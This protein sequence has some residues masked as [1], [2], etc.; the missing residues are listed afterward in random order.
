MYSRARKIL[1][2]AK[3]AAKSFEENTSTPSEKQINVTSGA[4]TTVD[5]CDSKSDCLIENDDGT[6]LPVQTF[7]EV[8]VD[9]SGL[10]TDI[11]E[12]CTKKSLEENR[13]FPEEG[14]SNSTPDNTNVGT[15][16]FQSGFFIVNDD[17]TLFPIQ[18]VVGDFAFDKKSLKPHSE[19]LQKKV[20]RNTEHLIEMDV[21]YTRNED[22]VRV[23]PD[24][25]VDG[26]DTLVEV[27]EVGNKPILKPKP[28]VSLA[29]NYVVPYGR[30]LHEQ[31]E[32]ITENLIEMDEPH[33]GI[34]DQDI[35]EPDRLCD[36]NNQLS[37]RKRKKRHQVSEDDWQCNQ[38]KILRE[39]GREYMGRKL[40][41]GKV[42][43]YI[44]RPNR[45]MKKITCKC[46][47]RTFKCHNISEQE[48][49]K[50]FDNFWAL[51]WKERKMLVKTS[52]DADLTQRARDRSEENRSRRSY[53]YK[54]YL[55]I[56]NMTKVR[57][58]KSTL[59]ATL[60][61]GE[62]M[63]KNWLENSSEKDDDL[64]DD[65]NPNENPTKMNENTAKKQNAKRMSRQ[66]DLSKRLESLKEFLLT[67][68]NV[69]SHYCRSSSK[70]LYLEPNW[71]SKAQLYQFY[72]ENWCKAKDFKPLSSCTFHKTFEDLNLSLYR[73]KKDQCDTCR[74]YKLNHIT[75]E[76]FET[77]RTKKDEAREEKS[78]DKM[79][80]EHVY[81]VDLQSLLLCPK[82]NAS[83]LYYRRKLSVHNLTMFDLKTKDGFCYLWNETEGE[84]SANEFASILT[85]FVESQL[86]LR[87]N[88][89]KI[90]IFSDGC[91]Y[92]NRSAVMSNALL[93][94]AAKHNITIESKYLE[95]GH[96]QMECDSMHAT[97]ERYLRHREINVPAD[98]ID[99]CK[100]ARQSNP[101]KVIYLDH[102]FFKDFTKPLMFK[103]IRP[104]IRK[105]DPKV[106][107]IRCLKYDSNGKI[108]YKLSFKDDFKV[109]PACDDSKEKVDEGSRKSKRKAQDP[110]KSLT[111][112][113]DKVREFLEAN[114]Q[115]L[116]NDRLK[117]TAAKYQHLQELKPSIVKD[118]HSF[119]DNLPM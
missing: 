33:T 78:K 94:V 24:I 98:Y 92:Q 52:T 106:T 79:N 73:P 118:Y 93:H 61:L 77:H 71:L 53:S 70:K 42:T 111:S 95:K 115:P 90:V 57:V 67:L 88:A 86:P 7:N 8:T 18:T 50:I 43:G 47:G 13:S 9:D 75:E 87:N 82:S 74:A 39:Q 104:G 16:D 65:P 59:L 45:T 11:V 66:H 103:S 108:H 29:E 56:D 117:I 58:C 38:A 76:D 46:K 69:E 100:N 6:L 107:D 22:Q 62:W 41:N 96:T 97:I 40:T 48:R 105:G 72:A 28:K 109:L 31:V 102:S 68:P 35:V 84:L 15:D 81:T 32:N 110:N 19:K 60:D 51:T 55:F 99:A 64:V 3:C 25:G 17:G 23:E 4:N 27:A 116:Y 26:I 101:Y 44:R 12:K 113:Q 63:V 20:E 1:D 30:E 114:F 80:E 91:N 5:S 83:S 85:H 36:V 49:K 21:Q 54:Y 14:I 2:L 119:Y 89:T 112:Y 10:C 37:N 34:D